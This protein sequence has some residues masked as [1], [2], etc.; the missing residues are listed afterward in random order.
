VP[1]HD[2]TRRSMR[3]LLPALALLAA[4]WAAAGCSQKKK[5]AALR[6]D[7]VGVWQCNPRNDL[8]KETIKEMG[9]V[10]PDR[11]FFRFDAAPAGNDERGDYLHYRHV[12]QS[13]GYPPVAE[14]WEEDH[15][16]W[17]LVDG[18]IYLQTASFGDTQMRVDEFRNGKLKLG[19]VPLVEGGC[20]MR[21]APV[22]PTIPSAAH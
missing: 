14:H 8:P 17:Y 1:M 13:S 6:A 15:G 19:Y 20:S 5:D 11:V 18:V 3:G 10:T 7:L 9:F 2:T 16:K 4:T 12:P 21:R 22:L